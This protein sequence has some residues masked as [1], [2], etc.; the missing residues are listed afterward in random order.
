[1]GVDFYCGINETKWNYHPVAPGPLACISPIY[2]K[3]IRT[4]KTNHIS[5]PSNTSIIQ[6]SGAFSDGPADRLTFEGALQRQLEHAKQFK[7][8]DQ[9]THIASY[10][11]LIDEKWIDSHRQKQRWTV[12][13]AEDAVIETINAAQYLIKKRPAMN[14]ILSAQGVS[15]NQYL[16][17]VRQIV[18][19]LDSNDILGLGGWCIIGKMPRRMMPVFR[20]TIRLI[21]PYA[22]DEN[23]KWIHIWGVIYAPAL[24]EL[25]WLCNQS[26]IKLSTDSAGPSWRVAFG[27]WGYGNWRDNDY[28]GVHVKDR[29]IE[30]A[31][32]VKLTRGW[33]ANLE[34]TEYYREPKIEPIQLSF[35]G[36][37]F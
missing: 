1:M 25:L 29:G 21:V 37:G 13:E 4:K 10:D 23:V 17:C 34:T 2:G 22:A 5:V 16:D 24:G 20:R 32:H 36:E 19:L 12:T 14:L 11:L 18:P 27:Q 30:R 7:Y 6:D 8:I 15:A 3:T 31:K 28:Q 33:L 26:G 35:E 9:V